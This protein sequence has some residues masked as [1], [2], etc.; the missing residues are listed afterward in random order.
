MNSDSGKNAMKKIRKDYLKQS[1]WM[2]ALF[3]VIACFQSF[4]AWSADYVLVKPKQESALQITANASY[5]AHEIRKGSI[6]LLPGN[7]PSA[8]SEAGIMTKSNNIGPATYAVSFFSD[9]NY[10]IIIDSVAI[11]L[12]G[13]KVVSGA[14]KNHHLKTFVL[15]IADDGFVLTLQ[16]MDRNR[17]YRASGSTL[18]SSGTV[19]EIDMTKIPKMIR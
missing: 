10:E 19:T 8:K 3:T 18:D 4:V 15:T 1:V 14:I 6:S 5:A 11:Q 13:T 2:P 17:L 9:A 7:L 12:D 16:D